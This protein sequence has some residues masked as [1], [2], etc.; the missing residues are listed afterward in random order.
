MVGV[1]GGSHV[2]VE[3]WPWTST[4][5]E[6]ERR[7]VE[8]MEDLLH[9]KLSQAFYILPPSDDE[10]RQMPGTFVGPQEDDPMSELQVTFF[11]VCTYVS[12]SNKLTRAFL[13]WLI[14]ADL[15]HGSC[16]Q[17]RM[18]ST[19]PRAT[20]GTSAG[21]STTPASGTSTHRSMDT[22]LRAILSAAKVV[23]RRSRLL[24]MT[25]AGMDRKRTLTLM[26]TAPRRVSKMDTITTQMETLSEGKGEMLQ[27]RAEI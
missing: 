21:E 22:I 9:R 6:E 1:F 7:K 4:K 17:Q 27:G 14:R 3:F 13:Y 10:V 26:A 12:R 19:T 8:T 15:S 25:G 16:V 11:R 24:T 20:R 5:L 18:R 23:C 2:S